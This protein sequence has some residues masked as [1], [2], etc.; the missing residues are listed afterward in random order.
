MVRFGKGKYY[1]HKD[2]TF[3][4]IVPRATYSAKKERKTKTGRRMINKESL[5][6][7]KGNV[8]ELLAE[9]AHHVQYMDLTQEERDYRYQTGVSEY[10]KYGDSNL[11]SRGVY[12]VPGTGENE[13]HDEIEPQLIDELERRLDAYLS[14]DKS[15][16]NVEGLFKF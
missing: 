10:K 8:D 6:I 14:K 2:D 11:E 15:A 12:G 5:N 7:Q 1:D 3:Y 13:A 4:E 16:M 9:L